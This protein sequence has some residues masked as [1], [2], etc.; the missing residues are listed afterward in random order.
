MVDR[1]DRH[2]QGASLGPVDVHAVFRHILHAVGADL[3][4][5]RILR[6]HPEQ[7]IAGRHQGGMPVAAAIDELEVEPVGTA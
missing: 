5:P 1:V 7:L 3:D 6:G 2:P 4:Q